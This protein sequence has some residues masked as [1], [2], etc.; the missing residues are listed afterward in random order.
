MSAA[1]RI[2]KAVE[3][4][5]RPITEEMGLELLEVQFRQESGH[6]ILRLFIDREQGGINVDICASVSRQLSACLEVEDIISHAY[7]LEISSPGAERPL[8]RPEDFVRFVGRRVKIKLNEPISGEYAFFGILTAAD[9]DNKQITLALDN[10]EQ[11][12]IDLEAM[13]KARLCLE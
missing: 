2:I 1:D 11:M 9:I 3:G 12:T 10:A 6:W 5:A 4:L 8:K 7:M 13:A